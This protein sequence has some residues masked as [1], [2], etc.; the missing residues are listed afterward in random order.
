MIENIELL[1]YIR[2]NISFCRTLVIKYEDIA[3]LDNLLIKRSY[4]VD[5]GT[6]KSKWR[7]YMN[8]SGEYHFSDEMMTVKSLDDRTVIDF[9]KENLEL[10]P[11]TRSA[12]RTGGYYY[13]RLADQYAH[14]RDLINGIINP[15]PKD[16]A[17]AARDFKI[18]RYTTDYVLWNEISLVPEL[19]KWIDNVAYQ[20]FSTEYK[21]TDDLMPGAL[22]SYLHDSM[23]KFQSPPSH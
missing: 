6:D 13:S 15:I 4:G 7:Y 8:L 23:I 21:Y 1:A 18:L 16:E 22:L 19:Q 10:H 14:Q 3:R 17:I 5:A 20:T 9:T 2:D 12:Y 11:A